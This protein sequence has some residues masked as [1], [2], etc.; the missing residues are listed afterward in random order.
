MSYKM[1]LNEIQ[2]RYEQILQKNLVGIYVHGSIAFG[3]FRWESS[4][5]DFIVVV[6]EPL[7]QETKMALLQV[8]EENQKNAPL[9]GLEMSVVL[10]QHCKR[11][12][13][14]TPY[15]LHYS[16]ALLDRYLKDPLSLCSKNRKTDCDLAAHFTV[17]KAVGIAWCGKSV[18]EVFGEVPKENYLDSI[19][20]DIESAQQDIQ[21]EPVYVTLN[22]CRVYAYVK[23]GLVLSKQAGGEWG[24]NHIPAQYQEPVNRALEAY[25]QREKRTQNKAQLQDFCSYMMR[26]I[27]E[28]T[29]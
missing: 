4:D 23:E 28:N 25:V 15:E 6:K 1:L 24:R 22:L 5:I 16:N 17:I 10:E 20:L 7:S 8:L 19:L 11:F 2:K 18:S 9:K 3:C 13:Y 26:Q 29:P 21:K 12:V 27:S 14:P